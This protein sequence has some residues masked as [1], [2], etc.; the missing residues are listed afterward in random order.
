[1]LGIE[2]VA[3]AQNRN[4]N[5]QDLS[6][7]SFATESTPKRV[8]SDVRIST[9]VI[10]L[11]RKATE[12]TNENQP[13]SINPPKLSEPGNS[14]PS[15]SLVAHQEKDSIS[16]S[17]ELIEN[18]QDSRD[19]QV[20]SA[21]SDTDRTISLDEETNAPPELPHR[22]TNTM[23]RLVDTRPNIRQVV[24]L[25]SVNDIPGSHILVYREGK[26]RAIAKWNFAEHC[27]FQ[28]LVIVNK[29]WS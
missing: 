19:T 20:S 9:P 12:P 26:W 4:F 7:E 13:D 16:N 21:P 2:T 15:R 14:G 23:I 28:T 17:K 3:E 27:R 11:Q 1:M 10:I 25:K 6:H 22:R 5:C 8:E 18:L 29:A 24:S